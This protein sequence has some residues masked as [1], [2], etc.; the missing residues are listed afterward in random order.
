MSGEGT[1]RG[2][3]RGGHSQDRTEHVERGCGDRRLGRWLMGWELKNMGTLDLHDLHETPRMR[4]RSDVQYIIQN[5]KTTPRFVLGWGAA[6][7]VEDRSPRE[8]GHGVR[9]HLPA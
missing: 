9:K 1:G 4:T 8:L 2:L 3:G 6:A 7:A 5:N